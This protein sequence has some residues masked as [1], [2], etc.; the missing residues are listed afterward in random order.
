MSEGEYERCPVCLSDMEVPIYVE[1]SEDQTEPIVENGCTRLGC[2][3][4]LHTECLV[5]SLIS[6]RGKCVCCNLRNVDP[7][8]EKDMSWEQRLRLQ[9]LCLEK[10]KKIKSSLLV[11]EGLL[12]YKAHRTELKSKH[13]E[14][15]KKVEEYKKQ[16]RYEMNIEDLIKTAFNTRRNTKKYFKNEIRK[17]TG[18]ESAAMLHISDY[19]L[20]RWLFGERGFYARSLFMRG[21]RYGFY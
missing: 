11:K 6:T 5:E 20:D 21:S 1:R 9:K 13:R 12:D 14:F 3:H 15:T 10:L 18:L 2:G 16:L 7:S 17:S 8:A 19:T 4:A